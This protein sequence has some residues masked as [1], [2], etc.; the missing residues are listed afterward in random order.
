[1]D[2]HCDL[3]AGKSVCFRDDQPMTDRTA[4]PVW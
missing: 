4:H 1:M 3:V 2:R